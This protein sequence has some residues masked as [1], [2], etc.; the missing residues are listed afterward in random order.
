MSKFKKVILLT[1]GGTGGHFFPALALAEELDKNSELEVH[2]TTDNRCK[3]YLTDDIKIK[4]H[5][6][7]LYINFQ[8][9]LGKLKSPFIISISLIKAFVLIKELKPKLI[10]GFGGYPSFPIMFI[11]Q[12]FCIPTI[13]YEQ[14][15]FFGKSNKF[16]AKRAKIIAL[17]YKETKNLPKKYSSK[18]LITGDFVRDNIKNLKQKH[19]FDSKPFNL[20]IIGGSQGAKIFSSL[21]SDAIKILL[22]KYPQISI[23]IIQQVQKSD[24]E[25][26][27]KTYDDLKINNVISDFFYDIHKC[28]ENC[29]LVIARSG[30]TTIAELTQIGMPAIFI[31]LPTAADD[32]QYYNAKALQDSNSSWFYRQEEVTSSILADKLYS[33]IQNSSIIKQASINL[34]KRKTDGTKYLADT[35]L[36]IIT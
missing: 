20:L 3:K 5:I 1:A 16:F 10:I 26:V 8:E 2:I 35:V 24:Q 30:A 4:S 27:K 22:A 13:I 28:Y 33:L 12:L 32:H 11:G 29:Q 36:K 9:M 6:V 19:N 34:L 25:F 18:T 23:N 21:I 7:D 17:A 15:S 14:N 31:P